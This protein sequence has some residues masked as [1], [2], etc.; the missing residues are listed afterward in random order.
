VME[1]KVLFMDEPF[2]ALDVLTAENLRRE[3]DSL[4]NAGNFPSKS[5]LLVTHNIEEA[6]LLA[7]RVIVLGSN[8][9]HVRGDVR[10]D[11][12]RPHDRNDHRFKALVEHL[13]AVMTNPD[14]EVPVHA[15]VPFTGAQSSPFSQP[16]PHVRIGG[17]SG[18]L[19]LLA[20]NPDP[21]EDI[22]HLADRLSVTPDDLL[23]ILDAATLLDFAQVS[24]GHVQLTD[25]GA[26]F[27]QATIL[28]SKPIFRAQLLARVPLFNS[29]VRTLRESRNKTMR[30]DFFID[31]WDEYFPSEEALRQF[32]TAIDWGRYAELFDYNS[33]DRML[34]LP[35][36]ADVN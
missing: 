33:D 27:V 14:L 17:L 29:I 28:E 19:E 22:A 12:P 18:L 34:H 35:E 15:V 30:A 6:V 5:I 25:L 16:L 13:Y 11:L 10:V 21:S 31:I 20:S 3:I 1:P 26:K 36:D 32:S 9:G 24:G 2:S 8:P 4:W 23:S 7:D